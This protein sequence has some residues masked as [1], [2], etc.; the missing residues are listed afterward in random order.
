[1]DIIDGMIMIDRVYDTIIKSTG[2]SLLLLVLVFAYTYLQAM[3]SSPIPSLSPLPL[4]FYGTITSEQVNSVRSWKVSLL[5]S[6]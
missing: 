3:A 2:I 4:P 6:D 1:M 5:L